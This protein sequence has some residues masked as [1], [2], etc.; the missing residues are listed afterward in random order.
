MVPFQQGGLDSLCGIYSLINAERIINNTNAENSQKLF[1]ETI[2][3]LE[4]ERQLAPI[5]TEGM[6]LKQIKLVLN[7][8]IGDRIPNK[9]LRFCGVQNP[10]LKVFWD[11]VFNFM[12]ESGE[13]AVILGLSGVHDHWTTIREITNKQIR[14]FDSD[15]LK[16]LNRIY[17][18]TAAATE[19][20]KHVIMPAQTFFLSK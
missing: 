11:D 15:G 13:R 1:N 16:K 17:C 19:R 3:F 9:E 20:R 7:N 6:L 10:S 14:L 12:G 4:E 8:V 2:K 18:T 5:L